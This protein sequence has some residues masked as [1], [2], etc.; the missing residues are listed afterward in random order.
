MISSFRG[1]SCKGNA[2]RY[3]WTDMCLIYAH[4][5]KVLTENKL[6]QTC[7][8]LTPPPPPPPPP[9]SHCTRRVS[10]TKMFPLRWTLSV[11]Q[12]WMWVNTYI[13]TKLVYT[14]SC[15]WI[16]LEV[17]FWFCV[18]VSIVFVL[19]TGYWSQESTLFF[20]FLFSSFLFTLQA[21]LLS[22]SH[23]SVRQHNVHPSNV[24][25]IKKNQSCTWNQ[26]NTNNS[27]PH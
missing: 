12:L 16:G 27:I 18:Y 4:F 25:Q 24:T 1:I 23:T 13:Y 7:L 10:T 5:F 21:S 19:Q 14:C 6:S 15:V 11:S 20:F 22:S 2:H 26:F 3:R 8:C 17:S 9:H